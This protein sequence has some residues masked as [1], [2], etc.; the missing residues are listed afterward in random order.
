[1]IVALPLCENGLVA[2]EDAAFHVYHFF[3]LLAH[4]F[5]IDA[6]RL[7]IPAVAQELLERRALRFC[8]AA[9]HHVMLLHELHAT[10]GLLPLHAG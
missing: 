10:A 5:L 6:G 3:P 1:M 9:S 2:R 4:S 7:V 8:A